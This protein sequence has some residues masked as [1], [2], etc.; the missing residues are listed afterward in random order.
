MNRRRT[1][2]LLCTL[3]PLLFMG[4]QTYTASKG[5]GAIEPLASSLEV[6]TIT[7]PSVIQAEKALQ[8]EAERAALAARQQAENEAILAKQQ[9]EKE[10][11]AAQQQAQREAKI[12]SLTERIQ[13]LEGS[14]ERLNS[15]LAEAGEENLQLADS[16]AS[17]TLEN[18]GLNLE[19][20]LSAQ[21]HAE[22]LQSLQL[23]S[24]QQQAQHEAKLTSL[25]TRIKELEDSLERMNSSLAETGEENLQ[26]ADS[27]AL[28][29][30][31]NERLSLGTQLSTQESTERLHSLQQQNAQQKAQHEAK[32][33]SLNARLQELEDS[34]ETLN[35]R[36]GEARE[37]N[38]QLADTIASLTLENENLSLGTQLSTQESTERLRSLQQKNTQLTAEVAELKRLIEE[39]RIFQEEQQQQRTIIKA[40]QA[41]GLEEQERQFLS[42]WQVLSD[43]RD[44]L[45]AERGILKAQLE[46]MT[47]I[48]EEKTRLEQERNE[49]ARVLEQELLAKTQA[50]E[51][52]A[53]RIASIEEEKRL[54]M[55]AEWGQIPAL[56]KI[57]YPR[58]YKTEKP[59]S[60]AKEGQSLRVLMLPLDD[61]P[62]KDKTIVSEVH[63]SISDLDIPLI[64]VTGHMENVLALVR[65]M[66]SN[67]ALFSTGAII[68]SFPIKSLST[69]GAAVQ[70]QEDKTLRL[71]V[72][73]LP[74]YQVAGKFAQGSGWQSEQKSVAPKRLTHLR[75]MIGEGELTVPTLLGASLYEPSYRD[76]NTFSPVGYRQT[77]YLWPLSDFLENEGFYDTYRLTH[78]SEGTSLGNTLITPQWGERVDFLYSRKILP[79]ASVMLTIG[80][81][82]APDENGFSRFGVLGTFLVP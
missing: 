10:S 73:N 79:L 47:L 18:E 68:S 15:S 27:L 29:T 25:D 63:K 51:A 5:K 19:T 78:F 48:I 32:L 43:E 82:S 58:L 66:R 44:A 7:K 71:V 53:K 38:L 70:Y 75:E 9:E 31:E 69:Y 17:L 41:A 3:L 72:A 80:G 26:L 77:D 64:F 61:L 14:L 57:T 13:E 22:R 33:T 2:I 60:L 16:L 56:D 45:K 76:W 34:L 28:L 11:L 21:E 36:L 59:S 52:E 54:A 67:A 8:E 35:T 81:E 42:A 12:I 40:Q 4:C 30:L 20:Q 65:E 39:N 49:E 37:E 46:E 1:T 50:E 6:K 23:Q 74:E 62:W 55:E 24:T